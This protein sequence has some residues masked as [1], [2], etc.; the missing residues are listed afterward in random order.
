MY[1]LKHDGEHKIPFE[2]IK[3][4]LEPTLT[5]GYEAFMALREEARLNGIQDLS[6][7]EINAEIN[8]ARETMKVSK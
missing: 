6:L 8:K 3:D 5:T 1:N 7:A 2:I 4:Q